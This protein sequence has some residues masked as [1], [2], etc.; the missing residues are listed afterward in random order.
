[1]N[2]HPNPP[3]P[4]RPASRFRPRSFLRFS[5]LASIKKK[6]SYQNIFVAIPLN[7]ILSS[8]IMALDI[9]K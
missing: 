6:F 1:M 2:N 3:P 7:S 8:P 9:V 4:P 5:F